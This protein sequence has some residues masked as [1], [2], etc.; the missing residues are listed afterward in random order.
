LST[1]PYPGCGEQLPAGKFACRPHWY[2]LPRRLRIEI[3][4]GYRNWLHHR[5]G[6][7]SLR[8]AQLDALR[9]WE[10]RK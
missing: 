1:C 6:L 2:L 9:Y 3:N 7:A 4:R 8:R 10:G 5:E